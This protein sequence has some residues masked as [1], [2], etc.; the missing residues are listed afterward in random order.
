[1]KVNIGGLDGPSLLKLI[2]ADGDTGILRPWRGDN[3]KCYVTLWNK[4]E[5]KFKH[6]QIPHNAATLPHESW[7]QID[8]AVT[9]AAQK[10]M[11]A[12][13]DLVSA[14][15]TYNLPNGFAK[16]VL[17]TQRAS[18]IGTAY[19][20]MDPQQKGTKDRP[21][22]DTVL[23]PIPCIWADWGYGARELAVSRQG[24]M[25][26]DTAAAEDQAR[27]CAELAEMMLIGNSNYDQYQY[28]ANAKIYGYTDFTPRVTGNITAPSS[29]GWSGDTLLG[30]LLA[31]RQDLKDV[32]KMGPYVLYLAPAWAQY[33]DDDYASATAGTTATITIRDRIL[34]I[35][36]ISEIRELQY[37]T[38]W[39]ILM[40]QLESDTVREV[41]G[42]DW[43]PV[44]WE[45]QGGQVLNWRIMG[46]Y[47]PQ[48][49]ADYE[50][51]CGI[52]HLTT[53]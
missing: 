29:S 20:G 38:G 18:R 11:R 10:P 37:L 7:M 34:K 47:V 45:E 13:N 44:Q 43:T 46:I 50:G 31:A 26:L 2:D 40:V 52:N 9:R 4:Q 17:M 30:E 8:Q 28:V 24:G 39:D 22:M 25:P 42:M 35:D 48:I 16:T 1:M 12:V 19:V 6:H 3:G 41:I 27:A 49:R 14:G 33:L 32:L 51:N 36:G 21:V 23:L 15:L 5:G 53:V